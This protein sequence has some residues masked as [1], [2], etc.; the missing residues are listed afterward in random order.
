MTSRVLEKKPKMQHSRERNKHKTRKKVKQ[1]IE[2]IAK[3]TQK[4]SYNH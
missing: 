1:R 3:N 4:V 2:K